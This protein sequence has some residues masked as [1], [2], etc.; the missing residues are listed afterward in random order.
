MSNFPNDLQY[1]KEHE[2]AKV[3]GDVVRVGITAHAV[4]QL[5]DLTL[6]DLPKVGAQLAAN[7]VFGVV[8]STKTFS[9]LFSPL[10]GEV[11]AVNAALHNAPELVNE[12]CYDKGWMIEIKVAG[13]VSG[14]LSAAEYEAFVGSL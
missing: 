14:L 9:D 8:E 4:N 6:V 3:T 12:S 7:A 11:V 13:A 1:T 5:G 2:W 10:A